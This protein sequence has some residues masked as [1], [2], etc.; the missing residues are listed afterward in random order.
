MKW[1]KKTVR[2]VKK[3][4]IINKIQNRRPCLSATLLET[5]LLFCK[6]QRRKSSVTDSVREKLI[7]Q[8]LLI[9]LLS[10]YW[11]CNNEWLGHAMCLRKRYYRWPSF[12]CFSEVFD[13]LLKLTKT[14]FFLKLPFVNRKTSTLSFAN[15]TSG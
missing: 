11:H 1:V 7:F 6:E 8:C 13:R 4:L 14:Y 2:V 5:Y 9:I 15:G 3:K 12:G 10:F